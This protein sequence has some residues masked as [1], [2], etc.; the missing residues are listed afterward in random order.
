MK[1]IKDLI[2]KA[3]R[4]LKTAELAMKDGDNDSCVSRA[5]YATS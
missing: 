1:E 2:R 3:R 4:F 5:Y